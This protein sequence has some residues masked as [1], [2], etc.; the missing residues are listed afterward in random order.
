MQKTLTP[1]AQSDSNEETGQRAEAAEPV[2]TAVG[3][4]NAYLASL[5]MLEAKR[6]QLLGQK[7]A[8][9]RKLQDFRESQRRKAEE[10]RDR[11][12]YGLKR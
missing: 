8:L 12:E 10:E 9:E 11:K 5:E 1:S 6:A 4:T 2:V 7:V 3:D